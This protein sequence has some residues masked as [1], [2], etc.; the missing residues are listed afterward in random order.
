MTRKRTKKNLSYTEP[1][2]IIYKKFLHVYGWEATL[3]IQHFRD[4]QVNYFPDGFFQ[5]YS[6][7]KSATT[8]SDKKITKAVKLLEEKGFLSVKKG[9]SN[10]NFYKVD[11]IAYAN[12]L[13]LHKSEE[14]T[15]KTAEIEALIELQYAEIE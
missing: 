2:W 8:L 14:D 3:L 6:R 12:F 5:Q 9:K 10:L 7:I 11:L 4:L 15:D 13:I 1:H